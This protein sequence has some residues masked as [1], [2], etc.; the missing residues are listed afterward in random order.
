[1]ELKAADIEWRQGSPYSLDYEDFY[2]SPVNGLEESSHVFLQHNNLHSR[3]QKL[4]SEAQS[5]SAVS[6]T[7][8]T[9][10]TIYSV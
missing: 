6:Y 8:L 1:M 9:L 7:H 4:S 3:W 10:P 5:F 2:W